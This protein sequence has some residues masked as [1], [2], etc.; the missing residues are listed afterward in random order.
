MAGLRDPVL[1]LDFD[2]AA[3]AKLLEAERAN[4]LMEDPAEEA[5]ARRQT[6]NVRW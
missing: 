1:A 4:A 5:F 2:L 3:A 6:R